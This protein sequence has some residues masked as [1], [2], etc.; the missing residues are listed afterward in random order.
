V[1]AHQSYQQYQYRKKGEDEEDA[2]SFAPKSVAETLEWEQVVL[3]TPTKVSRRPLLLDRLKRAN[4]ESLSEEEVDRPAIDTY[5]DD[6][7]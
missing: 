3:H 5:G 2:V 7:E 1:Q 6:K 4:D